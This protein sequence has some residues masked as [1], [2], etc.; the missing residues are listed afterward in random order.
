[1][2]RYTVSQARES[3]AEVLN[4]A[5]RGGGV[6]IERRNVE[7]EIRPRR[8]G[9]RASVT[10]SLI[11]TLDAAVAAGQWSWEWKPDGLKLRT[12]RRKS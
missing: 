8:M 4:E 6:V 12:R 3:L 1:M 5:E 9:Q 11:E 2:K 7:Y 10:P